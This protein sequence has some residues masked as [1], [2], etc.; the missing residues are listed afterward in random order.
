LNLYL[1]SEMKQSPLISVIMSVYN[2]A[3]FVEEAV[4]SIL[5][6]TYKNVEFIIFDDGSSDACPEILQRLA[7]SDSRIRLTI[8]QNCGI[9]VTANRMIAQA[10]GDFIALMDHDDFKHPDCIARQVTYLENNPKCVAVGALSQ[11]V[12]AL[13]ENLKRRNKLSYK[14]RPY[15]RRLPNFSSFPPEIPS[16]TN[17]SA[18]IRASAMR[19]VGGYRENL[20]Y[21]HDFDLWFRLSE[22]GEIH[23]INRE[24]INYRVHGNNTTVTKRLDIIRFEIIVVL[25]ALCRHHYFD[26]RAVIGNFGGSSNFDD[27][28][29]HYS[30]ILGAVFPVD[31]FVLFKA[32]GARLPALVNEA[33]Q[34]SLTRRILDHVGRGGIT[35]PKLKLL[36]RLVS[37]SVWP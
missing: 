30:E 25:S 12:N 31:T 9:P 19:E 14:L 32:V 10:S 8:Q 22:V 29:S 2:G 28:L 13:G 6:Q 15:A 5:K 24:L 18:L 34:A 7:Q 27:T 26:D 35:L 37:R 11:T 36:R 3:A 21:A 33:D 1:K 17:P 20:I 4:N 23:Q 16:I